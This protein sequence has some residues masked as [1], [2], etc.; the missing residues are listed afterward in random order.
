[1]PRA[2]ALLVS[3]PK[4]VSCV[5]GCS[6]FFP[7]VYF[8]QFDLTGERGIVYAVRGEGGPFSP[9]ISAYPCLI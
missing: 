8:P 6:L 4:F 2:Y 1:M 5:D 9:A 7:I 3:L